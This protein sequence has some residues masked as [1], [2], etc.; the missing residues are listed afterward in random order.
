MKSKI[1]IISAMIFAGI[2]SMSACSSDKKVEQIEEVNESIE[3]TSTAVEEVEVEEI[4]EETASDST[5]VE[6]PQN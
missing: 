1:Y 3:V 2:L 4:E 6:I 5:T